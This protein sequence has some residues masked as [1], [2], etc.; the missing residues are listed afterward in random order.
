MG[1]QLRKSQARCLFYEYWWW[2]LYSQSQCLQLQ[3]VRAII[4]DGVNSKAVAS[5]LVESSRRKSK[6]KKVSLEKSL[7]QKR[8]LLVKFCPPL[9]PSSRRRLSWSANCWRPRLASSGRSSANSPRRSHLPLR[10][11]GS[12][13]NTCCIPNQTNAAI[14]YAYQFVS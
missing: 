3:E 11:A 2:P 5:I 9:S 4:R 1:S 12:R 7:P 8:R 14:L 13:R 10:R 6:L